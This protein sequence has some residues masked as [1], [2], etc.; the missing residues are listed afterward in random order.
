MEMPIVTVYTNDKNLWLLSGFQYLFKK[1]WSPSQLVRVVGYAPPKDGT[2]SENFFFV[3]I[4]PRNYPAS[5]WSTGLLQ[6]LDHFIEGGEE[7]MIFM[8]EDYWLMES[9]DH[10]TIQCL[11][12]YMYDQPRNILRIDLTADRCQHRRFITHHGQAQNGCQIIRTAAHSPYQMSFQAGI[13]NIKL[14]REVL[15]PYENPWKS[16]IDG[17]KRLATAKERYVVLGTRNRPVRYQPVYRSKRGTMDISKLSKEDQAVI[18]KR[19]WI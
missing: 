4:N 12:E 3:S 16:E 2:L 7:F 8:L 13:W 19:G 18:L 5:E 15:R 10:E 14:L 17:S 1:Y 9:V 6:S 11:M